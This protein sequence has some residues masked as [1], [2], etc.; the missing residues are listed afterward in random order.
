MRLYKKLAEIKNL[1]HAGLWRENRT[2]LMDMPHIDEVS[3]DQEISLLQE[4]E[5]K[6]IQPRAESINT[7]EQ[8]T[9]GPRVAEEEESSVYDWIVDIDMISNVR[10]IL[11]SY[12]IFNSKISTSGWSVQFSR[13]FLEN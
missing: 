9:N 5:G 2:E 1:R 3:M 11:W 13:N 12:Q 7:F 6:K 8:N 4:L 10:D